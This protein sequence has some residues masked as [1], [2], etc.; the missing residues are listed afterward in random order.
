[1]VEK[2]ASAIKKRN[3]K[4][5]IKPLERNPFSKVFMFKGLLEI[6]CGNLL[7]RGRP[8]KTFVKV[9]VVVVAHL[10]GRR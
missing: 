3:Q 2:I 8:L 7:G 9:G 4:E 5:K 6:A 10:K 1:M